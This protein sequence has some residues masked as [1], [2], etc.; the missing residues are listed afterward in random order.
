MSFFRFLFYNF[1]YNSSVTVDSNLFT[2]E[3]KMDGIQVRVFLCVARKFHLSNLSHFMLRTL[4]WRFG[5]H[6]H[7]QLTTNVFRM[8]SK[9]FL[10]LAALIYYV[11]EWFRRSRYWTIKQIQR[12]NDSVYYSYTNI[13]NLDRRWNDIKNTICIK[14]STKII[15]RYTRHSW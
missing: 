13:A 1:T 5:K 12:M 2:K 3:K 14:L 6:A 10:L 8:A 9:W 7:I 15:R 11:F 4:T